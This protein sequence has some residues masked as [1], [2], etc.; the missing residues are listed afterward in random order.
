L[1]EYN[2]LTG[3][4]YSELHRRRKHIYMREMFRDSIYILSRA[5]SG[6]IAKQFGVACTVCRR[7]LQLSSIEI[8]ELK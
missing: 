3:G 2:G 4:E 6:S 5:D 8:Y 7:G 1:Y